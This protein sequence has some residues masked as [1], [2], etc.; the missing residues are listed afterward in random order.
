MN[1]LL[2]PGQ[3][4]YMNIRRAPVDGQPGNV[5]LTVLISLFTDG[6]SLTFTGHDILNRAFT[7]LDEARA[8]LR[9][10]KA[11][12]AAGTPMW[13]IIER[14]GAWTTAAAVVDD[15]EKGMRAGITANMDAV[16]AKLRAEGQA[17]AKTAQAATADP[18]ESWAAFR[19]GISRTAARYLFDRPQPGTA[20]SLG[21]V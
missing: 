7:N 13:Q 19:Q 8:Y 20:R 14:A 3:E 15:A 9:F 10:L 11:E 6:V 18:A 5:L 2:S 4:T 16:N 17:D 21:P 12:A 1:T